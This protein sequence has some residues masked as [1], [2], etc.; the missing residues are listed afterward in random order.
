MIIDGKKVSLEILDNLKIKHDK[1]S[2]IKGRKARLTVILIG[3][4][5]ASKIYVKNKENA[6]R[7]IGI[8]SKTII[9]DEIISSEKLK[10]I[11]QKENQDEKTDGIL[12]QLPL[13]K[14]LDQIEICSYIDAKKDVDGFNPINMGKLILNQKGLRPCTAVGVIKLLEYYNIQIESKDVVIIGRSNIV[15]KP[16]TNM[17]L[18]RSATVQVCHSKTNDIDSKIANADI[19]ICAAGYANLINKNHKLKNGACLIDVGINRVDGKLVGDINIDEVISNS[20]ISYI[21]PVPGGVGPMT[22]ACLLDNLMQIFE[23]V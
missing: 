4:N 23:G 9:L 16:L 3:N 15:G 11:I 7:K 8:E 13:P 10:E 14:H 22:I 6:C 17:L 12:V 1:L 19:L 5:E 2:K 21:T 18:N 20:D